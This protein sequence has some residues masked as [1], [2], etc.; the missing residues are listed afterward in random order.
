[1]SSTPFIYEDRSLA[2]LVTEMHDHMARYGYSNVQVPAIAEVNLFLQKAGDQIIE[3]LLTFERFG[4]QLALRPEFTAL[5]AHRYAT[6]HPNGGHI[7]RWQFNGS[8]FREDQAHRGYQQTSIGAELFGLAPP[9]ADAEMIVMAAR[10]LLDV[11]GV[12][13]LRLSLGHAGLLRAA[14]QRFGLDERTEQFL[15]T[16]VHTHGADLAAQRADIIALFD[17]QFTVGGANAPASSSSDVQSG[18]QQMLD[19]MLDATHMGQTMGGRTR[20]D[21]VQRMLRKT[22]RALHRD[23]VVTALDFLTEW[24]T[25]SDV[26]SLHN[27]LSHDAIGPLDEFTS[28]LD[29]LS[30]GGLPDDIIQVTPALVRD[31]NYYTG[32]VFQFGNAS[33]ASFGGGG[34]Y[35]ELAQLLGANAT[36]PAIG[37][38]YY[39]DDLL[40]NYKPATDDKAQPRLHLL[41]AI[42][43]DT[44]AIQW[45]SH[46]RAAGWT[47]L[48][49]PV[50]AN[51]PNDGIVLQQ[52]GDTLILDNISYHLT[53]GD[54]LLNALNEGMQS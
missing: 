31:W 20:Q 41:T 48:V 22:S 16:Q 18:T 15:L 2:H 54:M 24:T 53:D 35:D 44:T 46:L 39:M 13:D 14:L 26:K 30:G 29:Q 23:Q 4:G 37:F 17:D 34:R 27:L 33:G 51:H 42:D 38:A 40:A 52:S 32:V 8:V 12:T 50:T 43:D 21:I 6:A 45:A 25:A 3:S 28:L 7:A 1:M 9:L 49:Y 47:V 10:G 11:V 36:I 5:A 19:V